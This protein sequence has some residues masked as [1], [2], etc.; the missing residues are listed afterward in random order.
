[1]IQPKRSPI[2]VSAAEWRGPSSSAVASATTNGMMSR[3][4]ASRTVASTQQ[5]VVTPHRIS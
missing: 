3:W 5:L 4:L 1:M 2:V